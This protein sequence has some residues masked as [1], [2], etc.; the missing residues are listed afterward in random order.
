VVTPPEFDA[1]LPLDGGRGRRTIPGSYDPAAATGFVLM[2]ATRQVL[3]VVVVTTALCADRAAAAAPL[4]GPEAVQVT[5]L[6]FA[7]RL[8]SRL[9]QTFRRVIPN[10]APLEARQPRPAAPAHPERLADQSLHVQPPPI[11]PFQFRLPPPV[12]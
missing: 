2:R 9:S 11:S 5:G 4:A 3:A 1:F 8:V 10:S 12:A 7:G 6:N